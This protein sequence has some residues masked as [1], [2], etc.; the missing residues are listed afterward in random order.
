[1]H[2]CKKYN[3]IVNPFLMKI[4]SPYVGI[5]YKY[6]SLHYKYF[7]F[8][9]ANIIVNHEQIVNF[10]FKKKLISWKKKYSCCQYFGKWPNPKL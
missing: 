1:M 5:H 8:S 4:W 6:H 10:K 9:Y 3:M 2:S 7:H